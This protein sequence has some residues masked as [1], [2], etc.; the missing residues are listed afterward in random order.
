MPQTRV[1]ILVE[2][3]STKTTQPAHEN[4]GRTTSSKTGQ[5]A[6]SD[7]AV[8]MDDMNVWGCVEAG[9][10][11][12]SHLQFILSNEPVRPLGH[13]EPW[14]ITLVVFSDLNPHPD[15]TPTSSTRN[16]SAVCTVLR[17]T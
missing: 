7:S 15:G 12:A 8:L 11:G 10:L 9:G 5:I 14:F 16:C 17:K 13:H 4:H 6:S 1:T 3:I 2:D